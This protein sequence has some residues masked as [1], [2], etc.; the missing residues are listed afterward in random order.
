MAQEAVTQRIAG[1]ELVCPICGHDRFT[2][3]R[4][5]LGRRALA[6]FDIEWAGRRADVHICARCG[7]V[8]WFV[9]VKK[10]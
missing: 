9:P 1:C 7:Y 6:I 10:D 8:Y 3:R 2:H 4:S 5:L